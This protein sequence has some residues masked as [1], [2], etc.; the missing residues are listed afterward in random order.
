M[1]SFQLSTSVS[2]HD[3]TTA[4]PL[5]L[6]SLD[7]GDIRGLSELITLDESMSRLKYALK[8]PV[9]LLP[10]DCFDMICGTSTGGLIALLLGRLQLST[11]EAIR[12]YAS[13]GKEIFK[14]KRPTGLHSCA[15][16]S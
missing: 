15:F 14:N 7:G 11:A 2:R 16:E 10:A 3:A 5:R 9:D 13:L 6:L 8:Y 12:C 1:S 4:P